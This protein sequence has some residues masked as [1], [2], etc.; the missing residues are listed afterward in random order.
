MPSL[1]RVLPSVA[2]DAQIGLF[3]VPP[4]AFDR[5]EPAAISADGRARLGSLHF[6][7]GARLEEFADPE[8]AG[9]AGR[10]LGRQR[11]VRADDLVTVRY[12]GFGAEKQRTVILQPLQIAPRLAAQHF[13]MLGGDAERLKK[14]RKSTRLN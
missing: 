5:A 13:D 12:V 10:A 8:A 4:E 3:L 1:R 14:D 6:L 7:M 11:V 9:V 2:T